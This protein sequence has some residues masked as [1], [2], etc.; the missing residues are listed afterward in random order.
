MLKEYTS[1]RHKCA[2]FLTS[3][4]LYETRQALIYSHHISSLCVLCPTEMALLN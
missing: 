3:N 4:K 1:A 2:V